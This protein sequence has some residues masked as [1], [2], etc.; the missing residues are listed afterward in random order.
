MHVCIISPQRPQHNRRV[1][2][3]TIHIEMMFSTSSAANE[4]LT[5]D[6]SS[7]ANVSKWQNLF[8][9]SLQKVQRQV[10]TNLTTRDEALEYIEKLCLQLLFTLCAVPLHTIQDV[11]ERV[12]KIIPTSINVWTIREA[13]GALEKGKKNTLVLPVEKVHNLLIKEVFRYKVDYQVS[14]Y[15]VAVL[16]Y[17][18]ADILKLTDNYVKN[19]KHVCVTQ[20]DINV[21]MNADKGLMN[22]F[23]PDD[24]DN[25]SLMLE[26][27]PVR[28]DSLSYEEIVKDFILEENQY[29]RDLN[30]IIK[31]FAAPFEK[32]LQAKKMEVLFSNI[33]DIMEC[34]ANLLS[35]IE[36]QMEIA[37]E[38]EAPTAGIP[39]VEMAE[40]EEFFVYE[41]YMS[42]MVSSVGKELHDTLLQ[43]TET[44]DYHTYTYNF[45]DAVKYVLPK[46]LLGPIYHLLH[47]FDVMK[48]LQ[49]T[50]PNDEDKEFLGQAIGLMVNL[51][52]SV[53]KKFGNNLGK[54]RPWETS[55]RL[56]GQSGRQAALAKMNELQKS[57]DGWEGKDIWQS[58]NE[59]IMEGILLKYT[60][61]RPTE[62]YV[63]LFDGLL[64][65]CK[66]NLRR[67]STMGPA[68]EY[69]LKEKHYLRKI[70]VVDKEDTEEYKHAFEIQIRDHPSIIML[71]K[72]IDEKNTWMAALIS[73]QTRSMLERTLDNI[74]KEEE[75]EHPL[76]LPPPLIYKFA[77]EDS[78]DNIVFEENQEASGESPLI[79]GGTLLK[80][81]ERLTYHMY[82]DPKFVPTFLT[83]Y[84]SFCTPQTLL[85]LLIERFD[86]PESEVKQQSDDNPASGDP[87]SLS[88]RDLKRL[89]KEYI[90]PVQFRVLNVLR[91]WVERHFYDFERD[92]SLLQKL[93]SFL[94][95]IQGKAMRKMARSITKVIYRKVESSSTER[96]TVLQSVPPPF[97]WHL[98]FA[99]EE[100]DLMTLHPIEIARQVTL[101]EFDLYRAVQPSELVGSVW[102]KKDKNKTSPNLLKMIH[103]STMFTFWLEKCIIEAENFEERVAVV[104]RIIE[105]LLVFQDLNNFNGVL[106]IVSALNSAPVFRLEH[107]FEEIPS[108]MIRA[109][110]EAKELNSD[111]FKKYIEK[112]RSINPPCVPFL[113]MYLTNILLTEE[114]NPDFLPNRPEGIINFSKRRRV[115]EITGEIQQYQNQPYCF[116][117]ESS[118]REFFVNLNPLGDLSEKD[119][120]D[121]LYNKSLDLEPRGEK[122]PR[123]YP[124]KTD[125]NLKSPGIK[126]Q[127]NRHNT[128]TRS[129]TFNFVPFGHQRVNEED[130]ELI[131]HTPPA[132][133]NTPLTPT[134]T[135]GSY[136]FANSLSVSGNLNPVFNIMSL[137]SPQEEPIPPIL[138]PPL[139]PRKRGKDSVSSIL[140]YV[141]NKSSSSMALEPPSL[142]PRDNRDS[143][144]PPVP[145]RRDVGYGTLT[146]A[147]SMPLSRPH[148]HPHYNTTPPE[149]N[150]ERNY[151]SSNDFNVNGDNTI[152]E[153]PPKTYKH[154]PSWQ[155]ISSN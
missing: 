147:Q 54:R 3:C 15:I 118:I 34:S 67:S 51:K 46:L 119:F 10:I 72:S 94:D 56:Q 126:P 13:Q 146:L 155:Q 62:R 136:S 82:A 123:K 8:T 20:Q 78:S 81:V 124:R 110:D 37:E 38:N 89:R 125:F 103:H 44:I 66:Q 127:S 83:T 58:C 128:T 153:L 25:P 144:P 117:V 132:T 100:F 104:S 49:D 70:E 6:F 113:G 80:L 2:C 135:D 154:I 142:P 139:P 48:M 53:E 59:F 95:R 61:R 130:T 97:E 36:D 17:I 86:I 60:G 24:D 105:I 108:K 152:P 90:K 33:K 79:K 18:A 87:T 106:E 73:L 102:I 112:L 35:S 131:Q 29:L 116:K 92:K 145:P 1:V 68:P 7:E 149:R 64:V 28:R 109:F 26:E 22:L 19:I 30:M 40:E 41:K 98:A 88:L 121:Y 141:P 47:Y 137:N 85:D 39:F 111:H 42:D 77:V 65:L 32:V 84:R 50:S 91:H 122:Q 9:A 115:A 93:F 27:E 5:Y 138:P 150:S 69:K 31:V 120:N 23:F 16:E 76:Q 71:C 140:D 129:H 4:R 143:I 12:Q 101:L 107:T 75:K 21:A 96:G 114:G 99:S 151:T 55:L 43:L 57:I 52:T 11:E 45:K 148:S 133:P 74:L 134:T 63:F 14:L